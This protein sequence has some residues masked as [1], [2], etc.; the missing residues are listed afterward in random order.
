MAKNKYEYSRS[1]FYYEGKQYTTWGKTQ[2]DA[3]QKA[4]LKEKALKDGEVGISNNMTCAAWCD[5]WY[6]LFKVSTGKVEEKPLKTYRR[7]IAMIVEEVG[8]T[9]LKDVTSVHLQKVLNKRAGYSKSEVGKLMYTIKDIFNQARDSEPPL[10]VRN[11]AAKLTM[12]KTY[13]GK[14]RSITDAER[15]MMLKTAETH[16]AGLM[17]RTMLYCGLRPG[18]IMA[19]KWKDIDFKEKNIRVTTAKESGSNRIKEPKTEAGIREVPIPDVLLSDLITLN[20]EIKGSPFQSV[21]HQLKSD[22]PH[23]EA[24]FYCAWHS[25][26]REMDIQNGAKLYRNKIIL[27]VLASDLEPYCLRHT[28]GTDCQTAGIDIDVIRQWLGHEDITTTMTYLHT[29]KQT[30]AAA[31]EKKNQ[32]VVG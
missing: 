22:K 6:E 24:S 1:T 4:A 20:R 32:A 9:K 13:T 16:P 30:F 17:F 15:T 26:K 27:S 14:R 28:F 3:D 10:I 5:E 18:E 29:S 12:P 7:H 21:F 19:L 11:P 25:F 8:N 2:K 31:A 23:T